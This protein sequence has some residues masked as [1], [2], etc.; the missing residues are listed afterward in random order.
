MNN[1][2]LESIRKY[3]ETIIRT[4][5]AGVVFVCP[6][7]EMELEPDSIAVKGITFSRKWSH[8][9]FCGPRGER[10][11]M[12]NIP[13]CPHCRYRGY[14]VPNNLLERL[15][16]SYVY[17]QVFPPIPFKKYRKYVHILKVKKRWFGGE[18]V[19]DYVEELIEI[20]NP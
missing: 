8:D 7:C 18:K 20:K 16:K 13:M 5:D 9:S 11:I 14:D 12:E 3:P 17:V 2:R 1:I 15:S 10:L 19:L 4:D 6:E